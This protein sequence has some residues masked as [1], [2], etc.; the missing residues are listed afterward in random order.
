V[1]LQHGQRQAWPCCLHTGCRQS[2]STLVSAALACPAACCTLSAACCDAAGC[3]VL[4]VLWLQPCCAATPAHQCI[5]HQPGLCLTHHPHAR[6]QA[7]IKRPSSA[8]RQTIMFPRYTPGQ[9]PPSG[10]GP[11][12][13]LGPTP[14][15]MPMPPPMPAPPPMPGFSSMAQ[16]PFRAGPTQLDQEQASAAH[17]RHSRAS[18]VRSA[19]SKADEELP[20]GFSCAREGSC[21]SLQDLS[22]AADISAAG[23]KANG[24]RPM[25]RLDHAMFRTALDDCQK[26]SRWG[27][28]GCCVGEHCVS[29]VSVMAGVLLSL[30]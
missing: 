17:H 28:G 29:A 14:A 26:A 10:P 27:A 23:S 4:P 18:S 2:G 12:H 5:L 25:L 11:S 6:P 16:S 8:G 9:A 7:Q 13:P 15:P 30:G 1:P 24:R 21:S 20:E 3:S 19:Y 22:D